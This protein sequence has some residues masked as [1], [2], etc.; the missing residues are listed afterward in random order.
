M[1]ITCFGLSHQ[2]APLSLLEKVSM[3]GE[4]LLDVISDVREEPRFRE[5]AGLSTCNRTEFYFVSDDP[6][7]ARGLLLE[8]LRRHRPSTNP[9]ELHH[10]SYTHK[11]DRAATHLFRVAAGMDS[12]I[13]GEAQILGQLR[14]SYE[15]ALNARSVG[16]MLNNLMLRAIN[17]GR[18][19]RTETGIGKGN[20]SVASVALTLAKEAFPDISQKTLMVMGAGETGQL[21]AR[22]F[23]KEGIGKLIVLNRTVEHARAFTEQLGG[24]VI[25]VDGIEY[26]L[27][28]SDI[29]VCAVGAPH[30]IINPEGLSRIM[31]RRDGRPLILV[32][33]SMPR[34]ID[35][36]VVKL[37][38]VTLHAMENLEAIAGKN[39]QSREAEMAHVEG[40]I[41]E[42]I[43]K[44]M[45]W[46]H[47]AAAS[48]LIASIRRRVG[49]MQAAHLDRYCGNLAE[50]ERQRIARFSDS[51]LRS[52]LHDV[53]TNIR[54][55]DLE[56]ESGAKDYELICR[57]FNVTPEQP[58]G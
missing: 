24:Q 51:L 3:N 44:F 35:P 43:E 1:S 39:R 38:G 9:E 11:Q 4:Q 54:S 21:S 26:G 18:R 33:L 49:E 16:G 36:E 31:A 55:I 12:L 27:E 28:A 22:Q 41:G 17:F 30:Y 40:L 53:T 13:V 57:L 8:K 37:P 58:A 52:V 48:Q 2:T 45:R 14:R 5:F 46:T 32:D 20:V 23:V 19:V 7:K 15:M 6:N 50:E 47:S 56:T 25:G 34:N 42:E 10:H 29:V